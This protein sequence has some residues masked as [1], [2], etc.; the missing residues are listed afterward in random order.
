LNLI[1]RMRTSSFDVHTHTVNALTEELL[2]IR[3]S[4]HAAQD[5]AGIEVRI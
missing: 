3:F 1:G 2:H 5:R 4:V